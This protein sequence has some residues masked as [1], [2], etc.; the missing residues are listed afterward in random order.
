M[1][2]LEGQK[3]FA[4]KSTIRSSEY[5]RINTNGTQ[6]SN[7]IQKGNSLLSF[8]PKSWQTNGLGF[9]LISVAFGILF[10]LLIPPL[11]KHIFSN[12]FYYG[13]AY[14]FLSLLLSVGLALLVRMVLIWMSRKK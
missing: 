5:N 1:N 2:R 9:W 8:N 6:G 7:P 10:F 11:G 4:E 13:T 3:K 14:L 12:T